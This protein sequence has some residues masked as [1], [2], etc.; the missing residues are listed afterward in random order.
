MPDLSRVV[1]NADEAGDAVRQVI[2]A[3]HGSPYDFDRFDSF[4]IDTGEGE[5]AFGYGL[6]FAGNENV[7]KH[8]RDMR[9]GELTLA[10]EAE[11]A[12]IMKRMRELKSLARS[13]GKADPRSADMM[14]EW[15]RLQ[16][17]SRFFEERPGHMYEVQIDHPEH[18]LLDWDAPMSKQPPV[19]QRAYG[20]MAM[21]MPGDGGRVYRDIATRLGEAFD[22][23]MT[24]RLANAA[25][26][27]ELLGEGIPGIRYLDKGSRSAADGTRSYVIFPGAED[28]IRI[29]R[30]YAV[31]GA[32]G[33]GAASMGGEE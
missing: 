2:R 29:L 5:Q 15:A 11:L 7:A 21:D 30:K 26:S 13:V 1:R 22:Y 19:V 4:H 16:S 8:Y 18:S 31:P 12:G 3:Y 23:D 17:R 28:S 6:Y 24:G 25:A 32:V 33:A 20:G 10:E 9:P 27:K 14:D